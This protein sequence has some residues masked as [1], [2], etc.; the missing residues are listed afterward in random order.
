M[1]NFIEYTFVL[2]KLGDSD[3][4][5]RWPQGTSQVTKELAGFKADGSQPGY[6]SRYKH[7][8]NL[9]RLLWG[10]KNVAM[11]RVWSHWRTGEKTVIWNHFFMRTFEACCNNKRVGLTGCS[12]SGKTFAAAVYAILLFMSDP[13]NTTIMVSTTA[14]TDAERRVWGEIKDLHNL[15]DE[16]HRIGTLL[17][18]LKVITFDPG[19]E[20]QGTR[21]AAERDIGSGIILIPIPA[22]DEGQKALGKVIGTKQ[23]TGTVL[24][25][26]DELPNMISGV[27]RAES[28]LES[29]IKYRLIGI[30]NAKEKTDPH[31]DL[32]E[33]EAGWDS[34][35]EETDEWTSVSGA[36]ILFFHG[37]RSPN[38]HPAVDPGI[39][40]KEMYPFPYISSKVYIDSVA[41]LNGGNDIEAGRLTLDYMRFAIG[42]WPTG[43]VS[44]SIVSKELVESYGAD[45]I[46]VV[47][48]GGGK[49][50]VAGFDP[51]WTSGG[52]NCELSIGQ[53]VNSNSA[54]KILI[55]DPDTVVFKSRVKGK[56]SEANEEFRKDI[57]KQVVE[58]CKERGIKPEDF[59][60]DISGDGGMM[61]RE[62]IVEW[63]SSAIIPISS[64]E[65]SDNERFLNR[66]TQYWYQVADAIRTKRVRRFNIKSRYF[67]DLSRRTYESVSKGKVKVQ[68]KKEFKKKYSYS[69][70]AGD[71]FSYMVETAK[72]RGFSLK[73]MPDLNQ[74]DRFKEKPFGPGMGHGNE[75]EVEYANYS[76]Y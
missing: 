76:E 64:M 43:S 73:W 10:N 70:D 6:L 8:L 54:E 41:K 46:S 72:R 4:G 13:K 15:I 57:A 56:G 18:Y 25:I 2:P 58:Y 1:S 52:D 33:P 7:G 24:W 55:C 60:M 21:G 66:V 59:G 16:S 62:I 50:L 51:A 53:L 49:I 27:L 67:K 17:D 44:T 37:G 65:P 48:G 5:R 23:K 63:G 42:F 68:Q 31:G 26:I 34:I 38:F 19:K 9:I 12:S 35:S 11:Y 22:G 32:C 29:N 28:N 20:L 69:P 3:Y 39:T 74:A 45:G 30:G 75:D 71:S 61:L 40:E 14:G 47:F 36:K